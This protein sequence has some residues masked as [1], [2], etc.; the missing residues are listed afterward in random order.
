MYNSQLPSPLR[1]PLDMR[2][3]NSSNM[4]FPIF[5][6]DFAPQNL[7]SG[8]S[9]QQTSRIS[10]RQGEAT[11]SREKFRPIQTWTTSFVA[12]SAWTENHDLMV[13]PQMDISDIG[14]SSPS[15]S[16]TSSSNAALKSSKKKQNVDPQLYQFTSESSLVTDP[17]KFDQV[18][19]AFLK[20]QGT[21][22]IKMPSVDKKW[23]SFWSLFHGKN[24]SY[25][26][27]CS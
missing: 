7:K 26:Y 1:S 5:H 20:S 21:P 27:S 2:S 19:I 3:C 18:V 23:L 4:G 14:P 17:V 10:V 16:Y 8:K 24:S 25:N 11:I 6:Q 22:V 15:A 12:S 9:S 13:N